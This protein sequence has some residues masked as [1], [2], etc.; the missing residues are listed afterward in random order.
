MPPNSNELGQPIGEALPGWQ[1]A[2]YP[3][4]ARMAGRFCDLEPI[5]ADKHAG[6]LFEAFAEDTE[7]RMWTYMANGPFATGTEVHAWLEAAEKLEDQVYYAVV[8]RATG[9][10]VGIATYLRIQPGH[11]V[12]EVGAIS[13]APALQRTPAATEAMYLMMRQVFEVWGYRRYEWKC[14]DLNAASKRA[15]ERLGFSHDGLFRQAVIYKG[16]NRDTAWYSIIDKDWPRI[17]EA[18]E[19]WLDPANFDA[20]GAQKRRLEEIRAG[21]G[22]G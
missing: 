11:G 12:V 5:D 1:P 4:T 21:I 6:Q 8:D 20:D 14:D 2:A 19:A 7:G 3:K 22:G 18:L 9:R 13:Y 10:A 17:K 15:A 16:R